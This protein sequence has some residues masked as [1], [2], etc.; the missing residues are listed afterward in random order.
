MGLMELWVPEEG[1][2]C[3]EEVGLVADDTKPDALV[4]SFFWVGC[5][6]AGP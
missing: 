2:G 4:G 3:E 6:K 1:V 5:V